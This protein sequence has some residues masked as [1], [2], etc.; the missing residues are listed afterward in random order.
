MTTA[1]NRL[2]YGNSEAAGKDRVVPFTMLELDFPDG[3]G[4]VTSLPFDVRFEDKT[5][6][7]LS[8]LG[9]V[10]EVTE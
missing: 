1:N 4:R 8:V 7:G 5:Y 2:D 3:I 6:Y 10:S 9:T